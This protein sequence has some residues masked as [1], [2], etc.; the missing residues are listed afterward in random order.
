M[1]LIQW[2]PLNGACLIKSLAG[3][4]F[5]AVFFS[6]VFLARFASALYCFTLR[7]SVVFVNKIIALY[8]YYFQRTVT[9]YRRISVTVFSASRNALILDSAALS[10]ARQAQ[11]WP[12]SAYRAGQCSTGPAPEGTAVPHMKANRTP[13][14]HL[15]WSAQCTV[16]THAY[17]ATRN[18][19]SHI[20]MSQRCRNI[21][22]HLNNRQSPRHTTILSQ[23]TP[24]DSDSSKK[25]PNIIQY[26]SMLD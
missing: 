15:Y 11:R 5:W 24:E 14:S 25:Q 21:R 17:T 8:R 26:I 6:H 7:T 4:F 3:G 23:A 2:H 18:T 16:H 12:P 13:S 10:R 22:Q 19:H 20:R 1:E 9:K